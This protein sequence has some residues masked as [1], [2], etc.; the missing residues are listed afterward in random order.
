MPRRK[1]TGTNNKAEETIPANARNTAQNTQLVIMTNREPNVT[2]A[3]LAKL[4]PIISPAGIAKSTVP[5]AL[6]LK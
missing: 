3:Q 5:K 1:R 6:L 4:K 2:T